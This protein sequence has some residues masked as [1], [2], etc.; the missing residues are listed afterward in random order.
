[1]KT[2]SA[3]LA[4]LLIAAP[5]TARADERILHYW[6]DVAIQPDSSLEVTETI[7]VRAEGDAIRHGIYRDFPT[8]YSGRHGS[9]FRVGF[10]FE[11]ATLDGA[12]VPEVALL[13]I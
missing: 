2:W 7:D 11:N 6:S 4:L 5:T 3:V 8:R 12:P 9:Q 1:M 13:S 10:T